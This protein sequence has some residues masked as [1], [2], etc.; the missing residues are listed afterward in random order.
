MKTFKYLSVAVALTLV[1][2]A[3]GQQEAA[4]DDTA[5]NDTK[6]VVDTMA[7]T[8]EENADPTPEPTPEPTPTPTPDP[9]PTPNPTPTPAPTPTPSPTPSPTP[10]PTPD[11]VPT[12]APEP[13]VRT[14]NMTARRFEFSPSTISV[15]K[16]DTVKI[17]VKSE[18]VAHGINVPAFG[19]NKSFKEGE[20][21]SLTF[22]ADKTGTFPFL[23]S[24]FCGSGHG[25]M[26]GEIV[27]K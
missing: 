25:G 18:D 5:N 21:V 24:V 3:C 19:I 8:P 12:P 16:G 1:L 27:V 17:V 9:T 6:D 26:R 22:V 23:C 15:N 2:T 4:A 10:T 13:Q 20:T 7:E 11:P 14:I